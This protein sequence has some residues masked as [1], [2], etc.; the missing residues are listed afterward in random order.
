MLEPETRT[1][2]SPGLRSCVSA[3][4]QPRAL[5]LTPHGRVYAQG[6]PSAEYLHILG[7]ISL[8]SLHS[9]SLG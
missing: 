7:L 5:R 1:A 2:T 6:W 3:R 9:V 8:S 4:S